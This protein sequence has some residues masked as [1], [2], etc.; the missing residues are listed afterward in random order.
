MPIR[1]IDWRLCSI[2]TIEVYSDLSGQL[3][4]LISAFHDVVDE[5]EPI[6]RLLLVFFV[7]IFA[8]YVLVLL[9]GVHDRNPSCGYR[10]RGYL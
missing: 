1:D 4:M 6:D 3:L 7:I 2:N 9:G 8:D 5:L 10:V